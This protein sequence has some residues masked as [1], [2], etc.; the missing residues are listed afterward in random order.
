MWELTEGV[1]I[2]APPEKVWAVLTDLERHVDLAGS[3]EI[4]A[5]RAPG[6]LG[7]GATWE[8]DEKIKGIPPFTARSEVVEMDEPVVFGWR[9]YPPP[10][11]KGDP[12]SVPDVSWWY[13]LAPTPA[14]GTAIEHSV[15][16]V[17]PEAGAGM[18]RFFYLVS[19]RP[20][21]IRRGMQK[22]LQNLKAEL[23]G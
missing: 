15:R 11:K 2:S 21:T 14:G 18:M 16:I 4:L 7:V 8:A 17:P 22:T 20:K 13:R 3:G 19:R 9:S 1:E 10:I 5:I 12:D 23:G 6:P